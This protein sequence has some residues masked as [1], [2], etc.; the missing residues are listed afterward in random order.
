MIDDMIY[1]T[2]IYILGGMEILDHIFNKLT[3]LK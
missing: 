2:M 3:L 1:M